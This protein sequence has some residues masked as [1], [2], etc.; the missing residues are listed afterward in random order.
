M[1]AAA[2]IVYFYRMNYF[3]S[4]RQPTHESQER[5][6]GGP[7]SQDQGLGLVS[8]SLIDF[9]EETISLAVLILPSNS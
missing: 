2:G 8:V 3:Y 4:L 6:P 9:E 5:K 1:P 7:P